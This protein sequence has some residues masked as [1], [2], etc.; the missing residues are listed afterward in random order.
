MPGT[1]S[2]TALHE[3]PH[4]EYRETQIRK[5]L[6][7]FFMIR[8]RRH[9]RTLATLYKW[10]PEHLAAQE[11]RFLRQADFTPQIPAFIP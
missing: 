10:S 11:A 9:L 1:M 4:E 2:T 8:A 3:I 5:F 7:V 6:T